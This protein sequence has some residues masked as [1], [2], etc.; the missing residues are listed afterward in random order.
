MASVPSQGKDGR[1][2]R[3]GT[4]LITHEESSSTIRLVHSTLQE[5]LL[6]NLTLFQSPHS[7]IAEVC[8]TYLNFASLWDLSPTPDLVRKALPLEEYASCYW[9]K[10]AIIGMTE[11]VKVLALR[12]LN[13]QAAPFG[14]KFG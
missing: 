9:E 6:G 3:L 14:A 5:Y 7:L 1:T 2:G 8:L 10:H 12:L 13:R 11:Q 4:L